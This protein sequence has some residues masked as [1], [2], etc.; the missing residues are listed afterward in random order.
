M[1]LRKKNMGLRSCKD[2]ELILSLTHWLRIFSP[3]C[4]LRWGFLP[5]I[6]VDLLTLY[7][8]KHHCV[9]DSS[10]CFR[11]ITYS[12]TQPTI[13]FKAFQSGCFEV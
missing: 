2:G 8:S 13:A 1:S 4:S 5:S 12:S 10:L 3:N 9:P 6:V 11:Y 7:L